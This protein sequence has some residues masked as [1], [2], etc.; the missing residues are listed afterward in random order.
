MG[1]PMS[2]RTQSD[3]VQSYVLPLVLAIVVLAVSQL[4]NLVSIS[5]LLEAC[6][7]C[8]TIIL[9]LFVGQ[10][11]AFKALRLQERDALYGILSTISFSGSH[12]VPTSGVLA[13]GDVLGLESSAHEVWVYAYD[14]KY[15]K[16]D[17]THSAFTNAV[18]INLT[19]GVRYTY[20]V[21]DA[22]DIILRAER[23]QAYLR[24]FA[25]SPKQLAFLVASSPPLFNQFSVTLFNPDTVDGPAAAHG[26]DS[27]KPNTVA[28]FFPHAKDFEMTDDPGFTPFIAVREA[29]ALEIQ[30]KFEA[31]LRASKALSPPKRVGS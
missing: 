14:L 12:N 16:L 11:V 8:A 1:A 20:L 27:D 7:L 10:Y 28:V 4:I 5:H 3:V 29:G 21:P 19:R 30:E 9:G 22:P 23:M 6:G 18:I 24:Q 17:R 15:E 26:H 25:T 31:M 2:K 13:E